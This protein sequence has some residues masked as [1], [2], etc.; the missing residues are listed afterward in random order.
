MKKF[1]LKLSLFMF[2]FLIS[3][4][5]VSKI[6]VR[7][8]NGYG[9]DV[10]SFY[11]E[12]K[13]SMDLIFFGSS[14]S[15]AT[16]SPNVLKEETGL[17]SYNFST[18]QQPLWITYH[19][20]IEALKY[21]KPKYF[22]LDILMAIKNFE[23]SS[24][25]VNRDAIDK[26]KFSKNKIDAINVSVEKLSDRISYYFNIIKYHSRWNELG[27]T[28]IL[29]LLHSNISPTKGFTYL[30]ENT[31]EAVKY[32]LKDVTNV[33]KISKKNEEYLKKIIN[34]AKENNI[35]LILVKSPCTTTKEE[36]EYY[37]YIELIAK[38]NDIKYLNYKYTLRC[39]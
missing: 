14:H 1:L 27:K 9:T 26:M 32:D 31:A 3:L 24:E 18:Q 25:G 7:K 28:D 38:E 12:K 39:K 15:Y 2:L 30:K 36:Q 22:V 13:N 35:E 33:K 37:N 29:S 20:M 4:S 6:M 16:F 34:L 11:N 23:Y 8:G 5:V 17:V 19:Y 10:L 21:Q